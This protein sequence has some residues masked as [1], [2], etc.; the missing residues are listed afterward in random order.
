MRLISRLLKAFLVLLIA[1]A[2]IRF[3]CDHYTSGELQVCKYT[4]PQYLR[5]AV[6]DRFPQ[7]VKYSDCLVQKYETVVATSVESAV[8]HA[9]DAVETKVLPGVIT[10]SH[11]CAEFLQQRV[12]PQIV[13]YY[14]IVESSFA[15]WYRL[16][17]HQFTVSVK[18]VVTELYYKTMIKYPIIEHA[19][20]SMHAQW[21]LV[22]IHVTKYYNIAVYNLRSFH[23]EYGYGRLSRN[24]NFIKVKTL[25]INR[26][27][28]W[29]SWAK[30][31]SC[32]AWEKFVSPRISILRE[33]IFHHGKTTG[34]ESE[35]DEADD[36]SILYVDTDEEYVEK[37]TETSTI[38]LTMTQTDGDQLDV[39]ATDAAAGL[40]KDYSEVSVEEMVRE[41]F[42]SW[43]QTI[44]SKLANTIRDFEND[45]NEFAERKLA[46]IQPTLADL[47]KVASNTSHMNFQIITKA[48]MDVNCTEGVDPV[49][50]ETIWFDH[51]N[52]QLP[53]YMT[54]ELMREF[55]SLAH[56]Q[57]D[58]VS[59]EIRSHLRALA[60]EVND[61]VEILRQENVELF[62]EWG[63]IMITEWSKSLAYADVVVN[64]G[65]K[66][67]L[68]KQQR[69]NWKDFMKLKKQVIKKR[70]T[71]MEHPV[72]LA[73]LQ[74]FVNT[75]QH[76]LKVL[77]HENGEYLYILRSKANLEFQAREALERQEKD[78]IKKQAKEENADP[79]S[80]SSSSS[81]ETISTASSTPSSA[82]S[83]CLA[84][85]NSTASMVAVEKTIALSDIQAYSK[86]TSI[87]DSL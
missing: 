59:Q 64:D 35:N 54:R 30:C 68:E 9:R 75:A 21:K 14:A 37:Y 10:G 7:V 77:S 40:I 85:N 18:P 28:E 6:A 38:V 60:D 53:R 20:Y 61:H 11:M 32:A 16:M 45:I 33:K 71:L 17:Y 56:S 1:F 48:I 8:V 57:F 44:E 74:E 25:V 76:S 62:E 84:R 3:S 22:Q 73:S 52:T 29:F 55:F 78:K 24:V 51:R 41:E 67:S 70:D 2:S 34:V 15:Y 83:A 43:K 5:V 42:L 66:E 86:T 19:L 87:T 23:N 81:V 27:S 39:K 46:D 13:R 58:S 47:L 12:Y 49:T 72:K 36:E 50:N 80:S 63:D 65:N 31:S 79:A 82:A 69:Q 4:A 26:L